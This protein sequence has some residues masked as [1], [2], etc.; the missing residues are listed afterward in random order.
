LLNSNNSITALV[1][2]GTDDT[3]I[4][5][6]KNKIIIEEI[7]LSNNEKL[8]TFLADKRFDYIVHIGALRGGRKFPDKVYF[9]VNV[10]ATN[11]L[12]K[13]A[14]K[15]RAKFI[16]CSSVGV[17]GA[18]PFEVPAKN[19][20]QLK[21][22]TYYHLTKIEAEKAVKKYQSKK[23]EAVIVRPAI[24]YGKGDYGFPYTLIK[25]VD[26][27]LLFL[28]KNDVKIHLTHIDL[29]TQCFDYLVNKSF[30]KGKSYIVADIKPVSLKSL[31][32]LISIQLHNKPYPA[33]RQVSK[34]IFDVAVGLAR[35]FKNELWTSRFELI[36]QSWFY[37]V[38]N[39]FDSL[40]LSRSNTMD[41]FNIVIDWYKEQN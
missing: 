25:L 30:T 8:R 41:N 39:T 12:L 1:R 10:D 19:T 31:C 35:L 2:P 21:N 27:K 7:D 11:T 24:T 34:K 17:F 3:R 23:L 38:D 14:C 40:Q 32:D 9:E 36:S 6:F 37:E 18:I 26:K 5:E 28:P 13:N 29:L 4:A 33:N 15:N 20:T 16:F 22:D